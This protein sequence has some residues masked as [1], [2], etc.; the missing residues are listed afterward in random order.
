MVQDILK[1]TLPVDLTAPYPFNIDSVFSHILFYAVG[2]T[3]LI[4]CVFAGILMIKG[5]IKQFKKHA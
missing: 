1:D 3:V 2:V 5:I 4:G